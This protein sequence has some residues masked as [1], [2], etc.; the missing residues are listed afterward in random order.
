MGDDLF[1]AVVNDV[2]L[3]FAGYDATIMDPE[4]VHGGDDN[5]RYSYE[6][7]SCADVETAV[8]DARAEDKEGR[9]RRKEK[10]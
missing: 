6:T 2:A 4:E 3:L 9:K 7:C 8:A 1:D 5:M 10:K